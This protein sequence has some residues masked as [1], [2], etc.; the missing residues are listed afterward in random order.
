MQVFP[1]RFSG[2]SL[3]MDLN[4][5]RA[6]YLATTALALGGSAWLSTLLG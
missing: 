4:W 2:L 1:K 6:M 5:D 3:L